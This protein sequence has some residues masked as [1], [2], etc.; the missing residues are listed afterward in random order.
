MQLLLGNQLL[1]AI[2]FGVFGLILGALLA[3]LFS[4]RGHPED[5]PEPRAPA[6]PP[7]HPGE[8]RVWR[9]GGAGRLVTEVDGRAFFEARDLSM[10]QRQDLVRL[11][12]DWAAWLDLGLQSR[13][14]TA[15]APAPARPAE[16]APQKDVVNPVR[17]ENEAP[18]SAYAPALKPAEGKQ[19]AAPASIVAQIDEVLQE[20]L[21]SSAMKSKGIR[22][23]EDPRDGVTVWVGLQHFNGID[24]VT[25]PE[26]L[27]LIRTAVA[28]WERR[29]EAR[30]I[31]PAL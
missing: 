21:E 20:M 3:V 15:S 29:A 2:L 22:L 16:A 24:S 25:D 5:E 6:P 26:A 9:A 30:R 12:R 23:V 14:P 13:Q 10:Q 28:E 19:P 1:L 27:A 17:A 31:G 11:L 4:G 18:P 7:P 8:V